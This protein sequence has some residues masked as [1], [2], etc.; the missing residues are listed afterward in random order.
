M[1]KFI[2]WFIAIQVALLLIACGGRVERWGEATPSGEKPDVSVV[3]TASPPVNGEPT[4]PPPELKDGA[5]QPVPSLEATF[6]DPLSSYWGYQGCCAV[7]GTFP[8]TAKP[9]PGM[10]IKGD[11]L[12]NPGSCCNGRVYYYASNGKRYVF[13]LVAHLVSWF[14]QLDSDGVP[15]MDPAVCG[16]VVQ[17]TDWFLASIP[18]G[19]LV[20]YRPG[21]FV[22][23]IIEDPKR[24]VISRGGV[25]HRLAPESLGETIYPGSYNKR[26][27]LEPDNFFVNY[28]IGMDV[29]AA[30]PYDPAKELQ[31][32]L[33][34]DLGL[35]P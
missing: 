1:K 35:A 31:V 25:L 33:E 10:L 14:G 7:K 17:V 23:G 2:N 28:K 6:C 16:Q 18:I 22:T 24:Y 15:I 34:Q 21:T 4:L 12:S 27:R 20:T 32:T 19:G 8:T 9:T 13:P 26:I 29:S 11:G 5:S 30:K 3:P